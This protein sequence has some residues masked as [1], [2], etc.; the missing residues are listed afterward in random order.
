VTRFRDV[1]QILDRVLGGPPPANHGVFWQGVTRD[2]FV[3]LE[4]Y[5]LRMVVP[6]EPGRS[7]VMSAL[8]GAPP[9]ALAGDDPRARPPASG[10]DIETISTWIAQGCPD[11]PAPPSAAFSAAAA[12]ITV[13]DDDHVL[14]WRGVDFFFLPG[15]ASPETEPHVRRMHMPAFFAWKASH[16]L[17]QGPNVW[18]D[19]M[20]VP[21]IQESFRAC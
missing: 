20:A 6:G 11:D 9:F 13:S 15:L 19:Y 4:V 18:D 12:G 5:G 8:K 3:A 2:Q 7:G 10:Q 21:G 16:L 1:Q 14:Y 17:G